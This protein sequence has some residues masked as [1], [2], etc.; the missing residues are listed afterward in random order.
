MGG[1]SVLLHLEFV[2]L[3]RSFELFVKWRR[4]FCVHTAVFDLF[5]LLNCDEEGRVE[6][7]RFNHVKLTLAVFDFV[8]VNTGADLLYF[9]KFP[10]SVAE[11]SS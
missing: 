7:A 2:Q 11:F 1:V 5:N 4:L 9:G 6:T 3:R 10:G 8:S